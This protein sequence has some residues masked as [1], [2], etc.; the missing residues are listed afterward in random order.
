MFLEEGIRIGRVRPAEGDTGDDTGAIV[1][2]V[3]VEDP[4]S[5]TTLRRFMRE[6][7]ETVVASSW[8]S[9]SSTIVLDAC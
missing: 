4:L 2:G 9:R 3:G 6:E 5:L 8:M 1:E 7:M